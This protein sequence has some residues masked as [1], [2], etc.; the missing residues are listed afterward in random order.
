V[1]VLAAGCAATEGALKEKGAKPLSG[2][3]V[4]STFASA[5]TMK[6]ANARNNS[7]TAVFTEPDKWDVAWSNGSANGTVRFTDDGYCSKYPTLRS[8][9]EECYRVYR[10]S[11]KELTVF[12]TDGSYD[13]RIS[14]SK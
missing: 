8:G 6:W 11:D 2:T 12:K 10:T 13:A 3:E 7:G 9:Q 4:R 14:L 5:G 1:I